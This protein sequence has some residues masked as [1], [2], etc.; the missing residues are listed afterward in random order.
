MNVMKKLSIF[1]VLMV[2]SV[3]SSSGASGSEMFV[4]AVNDCGNP[5]SQPQLS[6]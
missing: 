5:G 4:I 2:M 3:V 6:K 1:F